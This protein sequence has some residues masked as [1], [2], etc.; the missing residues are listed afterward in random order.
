MTIAVIDASAL[1]DAL[2]PGEENDPVRQALDGVSEFAGPEHLGIEV[3]NV[4]R[5]KAHGQDPVMPT[6][7]TARQT[8]AQLNIRLVPFAAIHDRIWELRHTLTAYDAAYAAAAEH[9]EVSLLSSDTA[10]TEHPSLRC[11]VINPRRNDTDNASDNSN[12]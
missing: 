1:V 5:R 8:L 10:L 9:L 3:L 2:L 7:V 6:L 11:E 4:L 12:S